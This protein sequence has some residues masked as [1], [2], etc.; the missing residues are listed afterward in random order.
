M[1]RL[2]KNKLFILLCLLMNG[3]VFSQQDAQYTQYMYN[4]VT[5]NPAYAGQRGGLSAI[6]L[7]RTQWVGLEGAPNTQTLSFHSPLRNEKIG[8]GLSAIS[9]R[10]GP[11]AD[12]NLQ[13]Q[14]SYTVPLNE[15]DLLLS[16]GLNAGFQ[17]QRSDFSKGN[18]KVDESIY[19][20]DF[21]RW[22]PLI[23]T[24]VFLHS[25]KWYFGLSIPNFLQTER[26]NQ[27][28]QSSIRDRIHLTAIAGYVINANND[29]KIK[30]TLLLRGVS[31]APAIFDTSLN[32]LLYD[33]FT[34]G[35]AYRWNDAVSVLAGFQIAKNLFVGY[36]Y[37]TSTTP[38]KDLNSGSHE[39]VLRYEVQRLGKL[40]SPRFF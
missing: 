19:S 1:N 11:L 14:F 25:Q 13:A 10:I 15:K 4:T 35:V 2:R 27:I 9:D 5:I 22:S 20:E 24:G 7:H 8:L 16:F 37:D 23:G 34:F 29:I 32:A 26:F 39:I 38:I 17:N 6:G 12:T 40:L 36:A 3:I 30:P 31:G 21:N 28:T 18:S 33:K